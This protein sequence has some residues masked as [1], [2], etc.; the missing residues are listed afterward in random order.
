MMKKLT[1]LILALMLGFSTLIFG[2]CDSTYHTYSKTYFNTSV[3][4]VVKGEPISQEIKNQIDSSLEQI[5]NSLSLT[6]P[7]SK[8]SLFNDSSRAYSAVDEPFA[9][10][11][12]KAIA[13]NEF[14]LGKY[15]PA[16]YPLSKLWKLSSDTFDNTRLTVEVPSD[17]DIEREK[18]TALNFNQTELSGMVLNKCGNDIK[19]DFGGIAKGYAVDIIKDILENAGYYNG[20]ISIGGSSIHIFSVEED[21]EILHPRKS[22][23]RILKVSHNVVFHKSLSTSGDY[24]RHYKDQNGKYYS[25]IIDVDTGAPIDTGFQSVT[26]IG[27]S[28][29]E[30]DAIST[31][32]CC[33]EKDEFISFVYNNLYD[34]A[35]FGVY[36]K[37]GENLIITN[38]KQDNF[39]L[40]DD[41]YLVK[42]VI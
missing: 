36:E 39:T 21:L 10:I 40:L 6:N 23:E 18:A 26:V 4:A 32:L 8:L 19:L 1:A 41:S 17:L 2:G 30:C 16:V 38:E 28:A 24:V 14:T 25:H 42:Y 12:Q 33:L 3:Y 9:Q 20:Y 7:N 27:K 11:Y 37:N 5:E 31:A 15:N 29:C 22:G 34:C 13:L 35:V